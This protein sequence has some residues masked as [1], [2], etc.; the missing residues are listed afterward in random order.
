MLTLIITRDRTRV[1][2]AIGILARITPVA[3]DQQLLYQPLVETRNR[4]P[5]RP[6]PVALWELR[7]GNLRVYYDVSESPKKAVL[8]QAVGVK[9]RNRLFIGREEIQL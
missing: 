5:M 8:I 9:R 3:V 2:T 7:V 1:K 4:K 6:N